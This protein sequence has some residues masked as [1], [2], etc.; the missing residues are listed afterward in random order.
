[1]LSH[2][3]MIQN[4]EF[5]MKQNSQRVFQYFKSLNMLPIFLCY[6]L[7]ILGKSWKK[8]KVLVTLTTSV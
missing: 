4:V 7:F 2:K 6:L 3:K 1:M 8:L 5:F